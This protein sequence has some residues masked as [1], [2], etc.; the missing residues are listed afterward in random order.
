MTCKDCA[1][2]CQRF[3]THRNGLRRSRCPQCKR[4]FT[5]PHELTLG[6]M[7]VSEEKALLALQLL[8]EGNS[9]RSTMRI[10]GIDGNT[11]TK[12]LKLAGEKCENISKLVLNF[13]LGRRSQATTDAFI[14]GLRAAT[15]DQQFQISTDGFVAVHLG[16]HHH[17][18]RPL[19]L[20][21][22]DQSIRLK[23]RG[24]APLQSGRS[25]AYG[26]GPSHGRTGF[27]KDLHVSC[28]APKS[29]D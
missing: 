24:R 23:S 14:E 3:G 2:S 21:P 20:R 9:I 29:Y 6:E 10:T 15:A 1:V 11:I 25:D 28:R 26:A 27:K 17:A 12:M 18:E 22:T 19:R 8:L 5:E 16:N 7:Y 4:T 13:A